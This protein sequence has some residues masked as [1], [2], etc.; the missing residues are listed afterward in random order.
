MVRTEVDDSNNSFSKKV[1]TNTVLKIPILLIC[2]QKEMEENS[3]TVRRY[4]E[5]D[6]ENVTFEDFQSRLVEEIGQRKN[7][8]NRLPT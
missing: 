8:K 5:K 6:Q 4:G 2:G 1:R 7:L 3:V